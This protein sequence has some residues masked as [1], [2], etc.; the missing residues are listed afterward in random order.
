LRWFPQ[1][2]PGGSE[3]RSKMKLAQEL[4]SL[5]SQDQSGLLSASMCSK[6]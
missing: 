5:R 2:L 1:F 3:K 6:I 4:W